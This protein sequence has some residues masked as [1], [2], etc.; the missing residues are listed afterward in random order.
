MTTTTPNKRKRDDFDSDSKKVKNLEPN[1]YETSNE[2]PIYNHPEGGI[3]KIT[4]WGSLRQYQD[5]NG[6]MVTKFEDVSF[7]DYPFDNK[8]DEYPATP[9]SIIPNNNPDPDRIKLTP[10]DEVEYYV[11]DGYK[12]QFET[13]PENYL[14]MED[15]EMS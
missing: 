15:E 12:Q 7:Q 14:T 4:P 11:M 6:E 8:Q 13:E 5:A 2:W 3:I 1:E 10:D 9:Q